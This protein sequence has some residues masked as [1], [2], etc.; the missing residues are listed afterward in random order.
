MDINIPDIKSY[1]GNLDQ[2]KFGGKLARTT[3]GFVGRILHFKFKHDS[4]GNLDF[5]I[6]PIIDE[7]AYSI[8]FPQCRISSIEEPH[9]AA[10]SGFG[11]ATRP[12]I[13]NIRHI[14]AFDK[15]KD[16]FTK[17]LSVGCGIDDWLS[18]VGLKILNF[19]KPKQVIDY[20][21]IKFT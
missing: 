3:D 19:R 9:F 15:D 5:D 20:K 18:I 14:F 12:E 8:L 16:P 17:R 1:H 10:R 2:I 21:S 11:R 6:C 4:D 7:Q 13:E